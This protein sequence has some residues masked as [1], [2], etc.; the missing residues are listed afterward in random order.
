[1]L[2]IFCP[3]VEQLSVMALV[4]KY[5]EIGA[6]ITTGPT[7]M[8]VDRAPL[9]PD[10]PAKNLRHRYQALD[11]SENVVKTFRNRI[12]AVRFVEREFAA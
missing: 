8:L 6:L 2:T 1:M 10:K 5:T 7:L 9:N 12:A 4:D 11:E 3:V